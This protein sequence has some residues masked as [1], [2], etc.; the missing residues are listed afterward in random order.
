[1]DVNDTNDSDRERKMVAQSHSISKILHLVS[2]KIQEE[3]FKNAVRLL[4]KVHNK[5]NNVK[6][7]N[8]SCCILFCIIG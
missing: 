2:H 1:M 3:T 5:P 6:T 4:V 8:W 7:D